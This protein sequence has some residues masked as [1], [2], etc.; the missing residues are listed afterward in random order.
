MTSRWATRTTK[1]KRRKEVIGHMIAQCP[2]ATQLLF[3][4]YLA[5]FMGH[6]EKLQIL[7]DGCYSAF[8]ST[9]THDPLLSVFVLT[10]FSWSS[11]PFFF[12]FDKNHIHYL[13]FLIFFTLITYS[14]RLI[15]F[16]SIVRTLA[17]L[18][19]SYVNRSCHID[20]NSMLNLGVDFQEN[21]PWTSYYIWYFFKV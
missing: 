15:S 14:Q 7:I 6:N 12:H 11:T 17:H 9:T 10:N 16:S 5:A 21:S 20:F 4:L 2:L 19:N 3:L 8:L 1:E 13:C 18:K